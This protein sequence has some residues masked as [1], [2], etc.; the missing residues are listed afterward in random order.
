MVADYATKPLQG[1]LFKRFRDWIMGVVPIT[2]SHAG[3]KKPTPTKKLMAIGNKIGTITR[4]E[5]ARRVW[6]LRRRNH[7][8]VLEIV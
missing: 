4:Q 8:S 7:R 5:N 1:A 3:L 2:D 6:S